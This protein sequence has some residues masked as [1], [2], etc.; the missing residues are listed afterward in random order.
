MSG[1]RTIHVVPHTHWDREWYLPFQTFRLRLVELVDRVLDLMEAEPGFVFT[2]DGQLATVD[3]YL[4]LRPESEQRLRRLIAEG[5]LAIGPW[6]TLVDEFLVSGESIV[7]N[8]EIGWRRAEELGRP[9]PIGYLPD[10]FGHVAQMPQ[11]LRRAGIDQAVVWRGVPA[12]I[13]HHAFVWESPDGSA[14]RAEYLIDGYGNAAHL[15]GEPDLAGAVAAFDASM[16]PFFGEDESLAMTGTDHMLPPLDLVERATQFNE[17]QDRF[18]L[19]LV[20]LAD[21]L[22]RPADGAL[23]ARWRGE[24]RSAARANLLM[25]VTS[26]R[27]DLKAAC[28]RAER[29]LER[30]AEPLA[31][32]YAPEWPASFLRLAWSRV[33][34]NAAH[35][36]ICGCSVDA[37]SA[38]VLVRYAEAEQIAT[39]LARRAAEA[40]A[41]GV[42]RGAVA[43]VNPSPERRSDVVELELEIPDDWDEVDLR[44]PD[45]TVVAT[46]ETARPERL[47]L[48]ITLA[49]RELPAALFRRLHGR[50]L[51]GR[52]LNGY[53]VEGG[54][55]ARRLTFD[56]GE[57]PDPE[58]LDLAV[59]KQ[60]VSHAV[61]GAPDDEWELRI[62][63]R[64][65]RRLAA[66]ILGP[67]L[68]WTSARPARASGRS[69]GGVQVDGTSMDNG[70]LEVE[71]AKDGTLRVGS[72]HGVGRLVD[73]GDF[74]DSYNYGPPRHDTLVA[75][76]E[77]VSVE[78]VAAGPV[79]GELAVVRSYRWPV[80]VRPDGS[81]RAEDTALVPVTMR[82][83]LRTGEPFVRIELSFDNP[84]SDHRLRFHVPLPAPVETTWAEGQFAVVG[85]GLEPE[86]G[87]GEVPLATAPARGF[88][89]A[90][91][92]AA[93]LDHVLEYELV[94][95]R[96]LALT[97]LRSIGLIS[98][99]ANPYREDPAGPEVA[100]PDGQC[101][102]PWRVGFALYPHEGSW[103]EAGVLAQME[104]YQHPFL[105][106]RGTGGEEPAE[107]T[108]LE[109]VGEGVALSSLRRRED[110]L[111]LRI[112]CQQPEPRTAVVRGG[113]REAREA[114]LLG[115][116]G[117]PIP[118]DGDALR[119]ELGPWEILT[120]HLRR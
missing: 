112:V 85:R 7:R 91:G 1:P 65:R 23:L 36:S 78:I 90:G 39:G 118:L 88:V 72:L 67:A 107:A 81:A 111:E 89:A 5:R 44:L 115:R 76:P 66:A 3:D 95:S 6:Q 38:Q 50:E 110:W 58:W 15:F 52:W 73:G 17:A 43:V 27:I 12:A 87:H 45:G 79:R 11:I 21:Y 68:G 4:E 102:E 14:V 64:P 25:G 94:E 75:E 106:A 60:E 116:P 71:V 30:Y 20:T 77:T 40:I 55:V 31:A 69:R 32:L 97:V 28:A 54:P 84:C 113:F 41:A 49:G 24:L 63:A 35:D 104:R 92:V 74:G 47:L 48:S 56:V 57:E 18:R 101:R 59:L 29:A 16:R 93:L 70:L 9:M 19:E 51:F 86:G 103:G 13:E 34:E 108:G 33:L 83:E 109:L 61:E 105:V 53:S 37:V 2:L 114:D 82:V 46:Q 119:L 42:P 99:S 10:M 8:L 98:R 100:I 117:S 62:L 22:G 80:G 26:A 96:E 120:V